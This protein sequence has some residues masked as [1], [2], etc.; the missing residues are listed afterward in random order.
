MV[1]PTWFAPNSTSLAW[2]LLAVGRGG[3]PPLVAVRR[4]VEDAQWMQ[5]LPDAVPWFALST[6]AALRAALED[7]TPLRLK[8]AHDPELYRRPDEAPNPPVNDRGQL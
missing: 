5:A 3:G 2:V 1:S 8:Q 6:A 4:V 7:G